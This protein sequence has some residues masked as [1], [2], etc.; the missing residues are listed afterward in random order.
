MTA[1]SNVRVVLP[2]GILLVL[3][4]I[5]LAVFAAS[6]LTARIAERGVPLVDAGG[7]VD[8]PGDPGS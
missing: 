5:T 8:E 7:D 1:R 6:A 3:N 4:L 2:I